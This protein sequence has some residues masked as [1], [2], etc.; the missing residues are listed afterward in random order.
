[1]YDKPALLNTSY[2]IG[3]WKSLLRIRDA[4]LSTA[5]VL[6]INIFID[7]WRQ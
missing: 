1:M 4:G 6:P 5:K 2:G 3:G 7:S